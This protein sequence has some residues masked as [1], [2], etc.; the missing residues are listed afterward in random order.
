MNAPEGVHR[1]IEVAF[2]DNA[3]DQLCAAML[4]R[5]DGLPGPQRQALETVLGLSTGA[6]PGRL[7][8][9][10]AAL[11]VLSEVAEERPLLCVVD[12]AQWLDKASLRT[13][14]LLRC[15]S[16]AENGATRSR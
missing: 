15:S 1:I 11:S 7:L 6:L 8:V 10:L 5:L 16:V 14:P 12:D 9:G 2:S 13:A 4:D 3:L